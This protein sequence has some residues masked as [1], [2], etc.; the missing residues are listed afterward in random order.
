MRCVQG[1]RFVHVLSSGGKAEAVSWLHRKIS[2]ER[3]GFEDAL[4][5]SAGDAE[6]DIDMLQVTDLALLVRSPVYAPP[7]IARAGGLIISD[8]L[9]PDGW[10]EGIETLLDRVMEDRVS[11]RFLPKRH[12]YN[13]A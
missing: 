2:T 1:A 9:G 12:D 6:N 11:G 3:P 5:I 13:A 7:Q 10:S 4:S 8:Q